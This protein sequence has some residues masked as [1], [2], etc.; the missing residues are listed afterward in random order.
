MVI[1]ILEDVFTVIKVYKCFRQADYQQWHTIE[2]KP[3]EDTDHRH[4]SQW[5]LR[6]PRGFDLYQ[7]WII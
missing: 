3:L 2:L 5:H 1:L 4:G 7:F 6:S